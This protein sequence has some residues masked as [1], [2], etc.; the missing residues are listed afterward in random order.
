[1]R[2]NVLV[3]ANCFSKKK[4]RIVLTS[5]LVENRKL[6]YVKPVVRYFLAQWTAD[7]WSRCI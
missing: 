3:V 4:N 1:M 5:F 6:N 7:K 2:I